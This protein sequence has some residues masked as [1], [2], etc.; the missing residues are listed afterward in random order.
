MSKNL[1]PQRVL[2]SC[3]AIEWPVAKRGTL[4]AARFQLRKIS[5]AIIAVC[6]EGTHNPEVAQLT[7]ALAM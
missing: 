5:R 3:T 4:R 7:S 1:V 6:D 2:P